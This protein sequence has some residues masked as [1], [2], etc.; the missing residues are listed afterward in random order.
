LQKKLDI[1]PHIVFHREEISDVEE[2][3]ECD[4]PFSQDYDKLSKLSYDE[5]YA[6]EVKKRR[7][8]K[9]RKQEALKK[10]QDKLK[11]IQ[12]AVENIL[13]HRDA[14]TKAENKIKEMKADKSKKYFLGKWKE[15]F[16]HEKDLGNFFESIDN[17]LIEN[18]AKADSVEAKKKKNI[19]K[20]QDDNY[21]EQKFKRSNLAH[22][23]QFLY[24][25]IK[26]ERKF[27][28]HEKFQNM[29]SKII[30]KLNKKV[31][32]SEQAVFGLFQRRQSSHLVFAKKTR[33]RTT[34]CFPPGRNFGRRGAL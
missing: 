15:N 34:Y 18:Q 16:K 21:T 31:E 2:L 24:T 5:K 33:Y 9:E 12:D 1:E 26:R 29:V 7:E 11:R 32:E 25:N 23:G 8:K 20:D 6:Y 4:R 17:L 19:A 28:K 27:P 14:I 22:R 30:P 10:K 3:C 13:E